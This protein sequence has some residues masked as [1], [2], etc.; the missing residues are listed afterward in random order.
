MIISPHPCRRRSRS[1]DH[2]ADFLP[3]NLGAPAGRA[4][5]PCW[6][7]KAANR[8]HRL[9]SGIL[10]FFTGR[11]LVQRF[12][13][14]WEIGLSPPVPYAHPSGGSRSKKSEQEAYGLQQ[15]ELN[16]L[17]GFGVFLLERSNTWLFN[18]TL[19]VLP[20]CPGERFGPKLPLTGLSAAGPRDCPVLETG[21]SEYSK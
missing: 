10:D 11:W 16:Y 15:L 12:L 18:P 7:G 14:G 2:V 13:A 3:A 5:T 8:C 1:E 4:V 9:S 21:T 20:F 17:L 19:I 6:H